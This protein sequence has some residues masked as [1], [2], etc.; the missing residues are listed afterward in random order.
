MKNLRWII[1]L[2]CIAL[3]IFLWLAP[4]TDFVDG[5]F[6]VNDV[7]GTVGKKAVLG[8]TRIFY[9]YY[10]SVLLFTLPRNKCIFL[11]LLSFIGIEFHGK[12]I[13]V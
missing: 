13:Y 12:S 6:Y 3:Q 5:I 11:I 8:S 2:F 7:G 4:D 1:F 9:I 10:G